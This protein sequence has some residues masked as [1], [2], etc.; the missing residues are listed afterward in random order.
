MKLA[1]VSLGCHKN[2]VDSEN[3]LGILVNKKGFDLTSEIEEADV[4]VVNTCGFIN[5]AKEE[6][7]NAILEVATLKR[8]GKLKKLIVSGCLAQRYAA[9]LIDEIP[10]IDAILGTGEIDKIEEVIDEVFK[11]NIVIKSES[12][13]FLTSNE[14]E[15]I[16]TTY[17]HTA[18]LKISEGCDNR[19]TF[20]IIPALRGHYR[21]R[22]IED[23]VKEAE[24][25]AENGVR[26]LSVISQD[27]TEYGVD[28]Y[29]KQ[30]LAKLLKELSKVPKIKRI[31]IFYTY[32]N[33]FTDELIEEI[34][35]ND[36]ICKYIDIPVQHIS[37]HLLKKMGRRGDAK[38]IRETLKK[39]KEEIEG[40]VFR[41]SIIV[42][43]PGE[44]DEDFEELREFM[45]EIQFD[46]AGIFKYSREEDTPAFDMED[47]VEEEIKLERWQTLTDLQARIAEGKNS[48]LIGEEVEVMIDGISEESEYM[49]EGRTCGQALEIDGKVLINDGTGEKGEIVKV[50]IEQNFDYDLL[51]GIVENEF[52]K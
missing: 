17:P 20:C 14:T 22:T 12:F 18:Y 50:K 45:N 48:N 10:E 30:E 36:K 1:L 34:K 25:L 37:D 32:P 40:V 38:G 43:F 46:Y 5:D 3:I 15:R 44:T 52:A 28:L 6:S 23:I 13:D 29:G 49:L 35:V 4:A 51:G 2:L 7:V 42:G 11:D 9:D 47:Q 27:S 33:N 31:R 24:K 19:C 39:L 8:E 16:L 26:E 21:S 41:T